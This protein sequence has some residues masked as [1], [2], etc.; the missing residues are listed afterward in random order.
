MAQTSGIGDARG[1][2]TRLRAQQ[3]LLELELNLGVRLVPVRCAGRHEGE[4]AEDG[5]SV[6]E[7]GVEPL[8]EGVHRK[9]QSDAVLSPRAL[10]WRVAWSRSARS[11]RPVASAKRLLPPAILPHRFVSRRDDAAPTQIEHSRLWPPVAYA[12]DPRRSTSSFEFSYLITSCHPCVLAGRV[13]N[14]CL[15][16]PVDGGS[17]CPAGV[18]Q[19]RGVVSAAQPAHLNSRT[20]EWA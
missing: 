12:R 20:A 11:E 2:G 15:L 14:A 19:Q 17:Q 6:E 13:A 4:E 16:Y 1:R 3:D 18:P 8:P 5:E 7:E 10:P 9:R